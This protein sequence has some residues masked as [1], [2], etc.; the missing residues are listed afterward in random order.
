MTGDH[1]QTAGGPLSQTAKQAQQAIDAAKEVAAGADL[2]Q[3]RS[4]AADAA[5]ALYA[6]GRDLLANNEE[7]SKA[8]DQLSD[9]IRRNPLVAVGVAF[10]AGL[11]IALLTRG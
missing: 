3:L 8:R 9:S 10:T 2:D 4:A 6:Q 1:N 11:L 7:L 5:S